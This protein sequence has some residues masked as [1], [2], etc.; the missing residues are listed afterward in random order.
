MTILTLLFTYF[1]YF[2][3]ADCEKGHPV[4]IGE[5]WLSDSVSFLKGLRSNVFHK[6]ILAKVAEKI[7]FKQ[8]KFI[9]L[10][11]KMTVF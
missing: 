7:N 3:V 6:N 5:V 4:A 10:P 8:G 1:Y 2:Y 9:V 11:I